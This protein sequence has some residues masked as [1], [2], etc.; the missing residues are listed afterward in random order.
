[1]TG[2]WIRFKKTGIPAMQHQGSGRSA[3]AAEDFYFYLLEGNLQLQHLNWVPLAKGGYG[4]VHLPTGAMAYIQP[5]IKE[6]I[7]F[8]SI[9]HQVSD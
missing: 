9:N 3:A 6:K 7:V 8:D 4:N 2:L 1:M 5:D